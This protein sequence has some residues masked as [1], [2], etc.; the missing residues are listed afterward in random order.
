MTS[1]VKTVF[2][3]GHLANGELEINIDGQ[4]SNLAVGRW[5]FC[6]DSLVLRATPFQLLSNVAVTVSI[7]CNMQ[8]ISSFR[9]AHIIYG[10]A[11]ARIVLTVLECAAEQYVV[12]PT[13][14][15]WLEMSRASNNFKLIV[16]KAAD[17]TPIE[18]TLFGVILIER[19]A[20][21]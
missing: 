11:P 8:H 20:H 19:V 18:G 9:G 2:V 16:Q 13:N 10:L 15:R 1:V 14:R 5:R 21:S 4:D 7:S 6:L 3:R 12:I 17:D